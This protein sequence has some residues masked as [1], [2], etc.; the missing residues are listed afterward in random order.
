MT[1][2]GPVA[3]GK[4]SVGLLLAKRLGFSFFDTGV[5]YRTFTC[6]VLQQRIPPEDAEALTQLA[7]ETKFQFVHREAGNLLVHVDGQDMSRCVGQPV[8]EDHVA[9]VS[10]VPGVRQRMVSEQ[11]RVAQEGKLIMAGRDIGTVVLPWADTKVFLTASVEERAARR[12]RE[13]RQRGGDSTY[14]QVLADLRRRDGMDMQ[15]AI[16]PLKPAPDA[17][18]INTEGLALTGVVDRICELA[19]GSDSRGPWSAT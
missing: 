12:F 16:S 8:V 5:L 17:V 15:R 7:A 6:K 11:R 13:L 4:S 1:I 10:K 18:S 14:E 19:L 9:L 2:D 3:V